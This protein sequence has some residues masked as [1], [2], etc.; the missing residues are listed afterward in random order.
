MPAGG[1]RRYGPRMTSIELH[2]TNASGLH[3]RP[4][5][6]F[7]ET[8]SRFRARITLENLDAGRGP[9][10]AK[11]ILFV[12]TAGVMQGHRIRI[13]ADGPDEGDAVRALSDAVTAG[14]GETTTA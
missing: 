10:D 4:A 13:S 7:V 12:L 5:A 3:A 9:V 11:S 6:Q 14:L 8:A 1:A 2:V